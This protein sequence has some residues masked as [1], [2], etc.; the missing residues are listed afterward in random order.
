MFTFVCILMKMSR[1]YVFFICFFFFL[2]FFSDDKKVSPF[3]SGSVVCTIPA[4]RTL[5]PSY[6]H[7]F[8]MTENYFILVEQ[9]LYLSLLRM[10]WAHFVAGAYVDALNWD[11]HTPVSMSKE[12]V[13]EIVIFII[14]LN[15]LYN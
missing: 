11:P 15:F 8:A 2:F 9:P 12:N 6:Y 4:S 7:S 1:D 10:A 14:S 13:S 3:D 5:N